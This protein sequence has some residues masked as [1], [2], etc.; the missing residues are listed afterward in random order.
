ML[1][2]SDCDA[3]TQSL[4]PSLFLATAG[5]AGESAAIVPKKMNHQTSRFMTR[6][7]IAKD[8]VAPSTGGVRRILH[9]FPLVFH[10][11]CGW[12]RSRRWPVSARLYRLHAGQPFGAPSRPQHQPQV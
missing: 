12:D 11:W 9:P 8:R 6:P 2:V 1:T 7:P 5:E 3:A 10:A 4:F